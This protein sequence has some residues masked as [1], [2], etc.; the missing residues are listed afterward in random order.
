[1]EDYVYSEMK[2]LG[3]TII[4]VGHRDSIRKYH[5][6]QLIITGNGEWELSPI[7]LQT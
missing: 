6:K 3:I 1:M 2:R 4:S 5:D 7:N